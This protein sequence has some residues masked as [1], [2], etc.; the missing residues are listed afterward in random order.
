VR[1]GEAV[2]RISQDEVRVLEVD[3]VRGYEPDVNQDGE[4]TVRISF[5]S[6]THN[7]RILVIWNDDRPYSEITETA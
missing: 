3:P 2:V 1:G 4:T 6:P 5:E 7:S